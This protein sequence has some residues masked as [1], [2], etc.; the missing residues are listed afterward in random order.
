MPT[1]SW[2]RSG[3]AN[4]EPPNFNTFMENSLVLIK[5]SN[6]LSMPCLGCKGI[7]EILIPE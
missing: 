2:N 4:E 7:V 3:L 6:G 5:N 1:T